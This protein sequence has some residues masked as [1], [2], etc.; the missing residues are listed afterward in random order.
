MNPR[1]WRRSVAG[2]YLRH[3]PRI[4]HIRGTW[5]HRRLGDRLF[6][7]EMWQPQRER[8]AAGCAIGVFFAMIPLPFQ[9]VGAAV[10]AYFGRVNIPAAIALTWLTNPL[11]AAFFVYLE[12]KIGNLILGTTAGEP[13]G[14]FFELIK[15]APFPVLTGAGVLAVVSAIISY[16]LAL[17]GYDWVGRRFLA[18]ERKPRSS[19][20]AE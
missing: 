19:K 18:P 8:F 15:R 12:Y 6:N 5:L 2:K 7:L 3:L 17:W 10:I 4:K 13:T 16:P 14:N 9:M 11:T 1:E 20:S